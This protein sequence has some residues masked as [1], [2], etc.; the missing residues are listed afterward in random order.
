M[1]AR[2]SGL[3]HAATLPTSQVTLAGRM[4]LAPRAGLDLLQV[5]HGGE[6]MAAHADQRAA[7]GHRPLRGMRRMRAR[8]ALLALHEQDLVFGRAQ[9]LR[10]LGNRRRVDPV[11]R[12]HEELAGRLDR[13]AGRLHLRADALV[14]PCL[15]DMLADRRLI[16]VAAEIAG[17]RLLADHMLAGTHRRHDHRCV[18][19]R[20]RA[21]VDDVDAAIGDQLVEAAMARWNPVLARKLHDMIAARRH[22]R[23]L[24]I[25]AVDAPIG[26]HVQ[27]GNE[28][29]ADQTDPDFRHLQ[30]PKICSGSSY[31]GAP[32]KISASLHG[33]V[34]RRKQGRRND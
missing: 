1:K 8:V 29:A 6:R 11:L 5:K 32:R 21:D 10:G 17:E 14:H 31:H 3:R 18:Q 20:R 19:V 34:S 13:R 28:A 33:L 16:A 4:A 12:I 2:S 30:D 15:R 7:A 9:H 27:L 26:I 23:H 25:D 24:D 22:R